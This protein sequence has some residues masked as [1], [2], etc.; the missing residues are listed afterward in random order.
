M[1]QKARYA[2]T[3]SDGNLNVFNVDHNDDGRWLN[4]YND[5]PD[6]RFDLD[7]RFVF[8]R[9]NPLHFSPL[10]G[11]VL[12]YKLPIPATQHPANLVHFLR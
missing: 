3:D 1:G 8:V 12:F 5:N 10:P 7:N 11:R 9:R 2:L 4:T 6:N